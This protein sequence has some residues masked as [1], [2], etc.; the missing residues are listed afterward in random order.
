MPVRP[1]AKAVAF[2]EE[3]LAR[4]EVSQEW[5]LPDR[6]PCMPFFMLLM[7]LLGLTLWRDIKMLGCVEYELVPPEVLKPVEHAVMLHRLVQRYAIPAEVS[8]HHSR[9]YVIANLFD[10][11]RESAYIAREIAIHITSQGVPLVAGL[12]ELSVRRA[13]RQHPATHTQGEY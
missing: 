5:L 7:E 9:Y 12:L 6:R 10:G 1:D 3:L 2:R 4:R 11:D 8:P 13:F